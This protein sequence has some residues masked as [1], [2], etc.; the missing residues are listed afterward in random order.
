MFIWC[1]RGIAQVETAS[2]SGRVTDQTGAIVIGARVEIRNTETGIVSLVETNNDGI[3]SAPSL[4][5]G[6]YVMTVD[7]LGFRAVSVT[8]LTL[9]VQEKDR[10]ST[11]LNSSH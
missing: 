2:L 11:R 8:G 3:Y 6:S 4:K 5:P 9:N 1:G 10:K 7:K